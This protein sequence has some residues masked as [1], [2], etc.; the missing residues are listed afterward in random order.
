MIVLVVEYNGAHYHGSQWQAN[1]PTIQG[2]IESAVGKLTGESSRVALASRTDAGVHARGQV[3]SF[4]TKSAF[5]LGTFVNGLNYYL[6]WDIAVKV[7]YRKGDSFNVR[8]DAC[9]R[10]YS[11]AMLNSS[12]R[13]PLRD[14]FVYLVKG[15]LDV[16]IMNRGCQ[17]LIGKHDFASFTSGMGDEI[18]STVRNVYQAEVVRRGELVMFNMVANAFLPH[19]V[20]N[21]VGWLIRLGLGKVNLS[22]INDIMK[23]RKHG[24]AG[25]MA[26]AGGLCLRQ[27][28][29]PTPLGEETSEN[30]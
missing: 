20:R 15:A 18:T 30:L 8:R 26:P 28:N 11:Y 24:M 10:W 9:S 23:L 1:L 19:Q 6:P 3:A 12:T 27:V 21:T 5:G 29:Y 22:Q 17:P 2:E 16:E 14:G 25:P 4:R 7:A 13:S